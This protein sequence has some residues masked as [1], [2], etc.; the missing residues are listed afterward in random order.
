MERDGS[1][2][3]GRRREPEGEITRTGDSKKESRWNKL[4]LRREAPR[5]TW[6][7]EKAALSSNLDVSGE[8]MTFATMQHIPLVNAY[9]CQDC[10]CVGNCSQQC[11]ACASGALMTLAGVL[12][13]KTEVKVRKIKP[14]NVKTHVSYLR[15]PIRAA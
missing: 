14:E 2:L 3:D 8:L 1:G 5:A 12:D 13:R 6:G 15:S 9:L 10:N 11:P 7:S 4:L